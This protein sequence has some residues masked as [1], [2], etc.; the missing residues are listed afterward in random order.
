MLQCGGCSA[1]QVN[2]LAQALMNPGTWLLIG[3]AL[4][5]VL[6]IGKKKKGSK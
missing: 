5:A 1:Q 4:T 2:E 6:T 3:S